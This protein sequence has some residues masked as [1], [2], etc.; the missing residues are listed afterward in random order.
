MDGGN[1]VSKYSGTQFNTSK[2]DFPVEQVKL[3][4]YKRQEGEKTQ[5]YGDGNKWRALVRPDTGEIIA[6]NT[7]SYKL[8]PHGPMMDNMTDSLVAARVDTDMAVVRDVV[9]GNGAAIMREIRLPQHRVADPLG[10]VVEFRLRGTNSYDGSYKY[11]LWAG[12]MRLVCLNGAMSAAG[13]PKL[14]VSLK[15][16]ARLLDDNH[17]ARR[18]PIVLE[19]FRDSAGVY[20]TWYKSPVRDAQ[21][22]HIFKHVTKAPTLAEPDKQ[23]MKQLNFLHRA[24]NNERNSGENLFSVYNALTY[25]SSHDDSGDIINAR[26][27]MA[28]EKQ[29]SELVGSRYW[30]E[31]KVAA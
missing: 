4:G 24:Y 22:D 12:A 18:L 9:I 7:E 21:V 10:K 6:I 14:D 25:W 16:T 23:N 5:W 13:S 30:N 15:H 11:E 20:Q 17:M 2:F 8:V 19:A 28:R 3:V 26:T 29:V 1:F 27:S 31:M